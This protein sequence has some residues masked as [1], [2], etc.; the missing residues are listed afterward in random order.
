MEAPVAWIL[1]PPSI[2]AA[3]TSASSLLAAQCSG[4]SLCQEPVTAALGS[5]P[6]SI[7]TRAT[8]GPRGKYPGQSVTTCSSERVSPLAP[9]IRASASSRCPA[10]RE[11]SAPRSPLWMA[12]TAATAT[13]SSSR[14]STTPPSESYRA[15]FARPARRPLPAAGA[16]SS[17]P[18]AAGVVPA[19][20]GRLRGGPDG[21]GL[22]GGGGAWP[23]LA[24][25]VEQRATQ[26]LQQPQPVGG[27]GEPAP[28]AGCP[29]Q[30]GPHEGEAAGLAGQP[31]DDLGAAAG[32]A[33]GALDEVGMPDPVVMLGGEPQV[34]GQPLLVGEQALHR[35]GVGGGVPGG[36]LADPGVN[37]L[38]QPRA[39]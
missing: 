3:A 19:S 32:L 23:Q 10:R 30:D 9:R 37:Q 4:V 21:F 24:G 16:S 6:A 31:A 1:A 38:R 35:R 39:R 36:H 5:A 17:R 7:R 26:V 12:S 33:E 25:W 18:G 29:V 14:S 34:G 20:Q 15:A 28:A 8:S 11:P 13:G 2:S 27:H 22:G